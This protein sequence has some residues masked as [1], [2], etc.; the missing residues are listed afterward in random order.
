MV[1]KILMNEKNA[2]KII[3]KR[4][5]A[6]WIDAMLFILPLAYT[7]NPFTLL[8]YPFNYVLLPYYTSNTIGMY[9]MKIKIIKVPYS[10][11]N[12]LNLPLLFLR[13]VYF[14][15]IYPYEN[16]LTR[17]IVIINQIGQTMLDK[18]F[19]TTVVLKDSIWNEKT[20]EYTYKSYLHYIIFFSIIIIYFSSLILL[21]IINKFF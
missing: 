5:L 19:N 8:I 15:T 3:K 13:S 16:V 11:K 1:T 21:E 4:I 12:K 2:H 18:R 10:E 9:L 17:G 14:Y 6:A 7:G 20:N